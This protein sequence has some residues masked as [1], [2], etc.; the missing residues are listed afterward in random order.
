VQVA[1]RRP[2]PST[3]GPVPAWQGCTWRGCRV[4]FDSMQALIELLAACILWCTPCAGCGGAAG[5]GSGRRCPGAVHAS[6]VNKG[7]LPAALLSRRI[8]TPFLWAHD[9]HSLQ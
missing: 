2:G 8:W 5:G 1:G 6:E 4:T 3:Q 7:C 9:F